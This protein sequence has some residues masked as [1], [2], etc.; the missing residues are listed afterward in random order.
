MQLVVDSECILRTRWMSVTIPPGCYPY[1]L[2]CVG[3]H[4]QIKQGPRPYIN[5]VSDLDICIDH[6]LDIK[7]Q[8]RGYIPR[9]VGYDKFVRN[10]ELEHR[11]DKWNQ[12]YLREMGPYMVGVLLLPPCILRR[13]WGFL[14]CPN[15]HA[16]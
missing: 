12:E 16:R 9:I 4:F 2:Y 3:P 5:D 13:V 7:Q 11:F 15:D 8:F 10:T 1:T 14:T 6:E